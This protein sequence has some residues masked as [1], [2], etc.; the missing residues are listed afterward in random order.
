MRAPRSNAF[1]LHAPKT[2]PEFAECYWHRNQFIHIK[3]DIPPT[4][5]SH[6]SCGLFGWFGA[7]PSGS[8]ARDRGLV[9]VQSGVAMSTNA[10]R[11]LA[12]AG[13]PLLRRGEEELGRAASASPA[14]PSPAGSA[15][16]PPPPRAA[17]RRGTWR[18]RPRS[19]R[20]SR[21]SSR[22]SRREAG[23]G[24]P[25]ASPART[26][27]TAPRTRPARCG[28]PPRIPAGAARHII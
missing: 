23:T 16:R 18:A 27:R 15:A 11:S 5:P 19:P 6:P 22:H 28:R 8:A 1:P 2:A 7:R 10:A 4:L 14:S 20:G 12:P 24:S 3:H 9:A 21:P 13:A 17:R 25:R 26:G